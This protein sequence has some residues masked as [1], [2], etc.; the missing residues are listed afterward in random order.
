MIIKAVIE[1]SK[2][3]LYSLQIKQKKLKV[4]IVKLLGL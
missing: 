1:E 3:V 4:Q 2:L